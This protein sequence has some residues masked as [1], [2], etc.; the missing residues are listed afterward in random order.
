MTE[1]TEHLYYYKALMRRYYA[2][3]RNDLAIG[4][5]LPTPNTRAALEAVDVLE[6]RL[7]KILDSDGFT[8]LEIINIL[9]RVAHT[10]QDEDRE[11]TSN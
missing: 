8:T 6:G 10:A 3:K 1:T 4:R 11:S 7:T 2:V 9:A 5:V